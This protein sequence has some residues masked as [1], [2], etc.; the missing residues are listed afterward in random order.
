MSLLRTL[1][2]RNGSLIAAGPCERTR[3]RA[4]GVERWFP[5]PK[6]GGR[7]LVD[8]LLMATPSSLGV[9][10]AAKAGTVATDPGSSDRSRRIC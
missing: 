1:S 8:P 10:R 2:R 5:T 9:P 7:L 3:A 6:V 4:Q